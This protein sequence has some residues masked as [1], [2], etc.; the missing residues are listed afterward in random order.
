[1][2]DP[3]IHR[4]DAA[5]RAWIDGAALSEVD[6]GIRS[7]HD[8]IARETAAARP[9]CDVSGRCCRFEQWGHRLYVTGLE[10]AWF[11]RQAAIETRGGAD[12]GAASVDVSEWAETPPPPD[13]ASV[14]TTLSVQVID[15]AQAR[16]DCP[17]LSRGR[18]TVHAIRPMG[19]RVYFCDPAAR[20]WQ[21]DLFEHA[22]RKI[23]DLHTA[24][25]IPYEFAEWRLLLRR[26]TLAAPALASRVVVRDEPP[27]SRLV[28]VGRS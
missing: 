15:A 7:I 23:A 11:L 18:C 13:R 25:S 28:Q 21:Q 27:P 10:A 20:E 3:T 8:L 24:R 26:L 6:A 16:G 17:F 14:A 2:I 9:R 22:H 5:A 1:M 4:G 19:C 12:P